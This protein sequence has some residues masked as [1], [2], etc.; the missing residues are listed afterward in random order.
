[1]V[2]ARASEPSS[3]VFASSVHRRPGGRV[4]ASR[5]TDEGQRIAPFV[6]LAVAVVVAGLFVVLLG[7]DPPSNES[8]ETNLMDRPAPDARGELAD[9][10]PFDLARRKG[11]WVVLNFFQSDCIPCQEEHPELVE[12]AA[13]QVGQPGGARLYSVVFDDER[14]DVE[15]FFAQEGGDWPIVY[16]DG[17]AIAVSFGVSKVPET[18]IV[19]PG[20]IIRFRTISTISA[21]GL[22]ARLQQLREQFGA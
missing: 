17:G 5:C 7:S 11:D 18:W 9:G 1:M 21:E 3:T 14:A 16:D 2:R 10:A 6:A 4:I 12:F 13:A 22:G 19:D 8:V 20:G 15:E